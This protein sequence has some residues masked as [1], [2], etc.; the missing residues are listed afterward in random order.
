MSINILEDYPSSPKYTSQ[1]SFWQSDMWA[2]ILTHTRHAEVI[3]YTNPH[4]SLLIERRKIWHHTTG[5][6]IL[7][8]DG[9]LITSGILDDICRKIV[10]PSDLFIQIEPLSWISGW[11]QKAPFRRFLEPKTALLHLS[12]QTEER[13]FTNF[14]EKGRYNIRVAERRWLSVQWVIWD[15]ICPYRLSTGGKE[16]QKT[17]TEIFFELLEETTK[18]DSFSH[19]TIPYYQIFLRTIEEGNAGW[20]LIATKDDIL[21]AG[22]IFVYYQGQAIYYYGASPDQQEIRRDNGT[23]L[24]QWE[25]IKEAIHRKCSTYDFL[26][27]SSWAWDKLAGVTAFKMR[28]NPE[29]VHLPQETVIILKPFAFYPILFIQRIRRLLRSL[30]IRR[31]LPKNTYPKVTK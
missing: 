1:N 15:D 6:Y 10:S 31:L 21:H 14:S 26:G 19:N 8:I 3:S 4:G 17:Y 13:L 30:K 18:R 5:L 25:A 20:L 2:D 24:L 7:G 29:K 23:Y 11:L 27:I 9:G 12:N 22:G 28:F 16:E